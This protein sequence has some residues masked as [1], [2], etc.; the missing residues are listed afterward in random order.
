MAPPPVPPPA[1][2]PPP[3]PFFTAVAGVASER[4]VPYK[5]KGISRSVLYVTYR[6]Q[7][8]CLSALRT[9]HPAAGMEARPS[10]HHPSSLLLLVLLLPSPALRQ[11]ATETNPRSSNQSIKTLGP[12]PSLLRQPPHLLLCLWRR[13]LGPPPS[14]PALWRHPRSPTQH[15]LPIQ[16]TAWHDCLPQRSSH[17]DRRPRSPTAWT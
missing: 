14:S 8:L 12:P 15:Q 2:P 11:N 7:H 16:P 1:A 13:P 9:H 17:L 4:T 3:P 6:M 10:S 5:D